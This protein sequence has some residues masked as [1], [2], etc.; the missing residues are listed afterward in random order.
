MDIE[1]ELE[2]LIYKH[3]GKQVGFGE[4]RLD[5]FAEDCLK[6]IRRLKAEIARQSETEMVVCPDCGGSGVYQEYDEYDRYHVHA[7]GKCEGTGDI[8]LPAEANQRRNNMDERIALEL[9]AQ[10]KEYGIAY[11]PKEDVDALVEHLE[12]TFVKPKSC[13]ITGCED[14]A[15]FNLV[16][17]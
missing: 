5:W 2:I 3:K 15:G 9:I 16:T 6:E 10:L 4:I 17:D 14:D 7:C 8:A 11:T 12:K 1:R 13:P